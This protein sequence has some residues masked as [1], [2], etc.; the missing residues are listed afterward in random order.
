M[1]EMP[2]GAAQTFVASHAKDSAFEAGLRSF[3]EYRDLGVAKAT[4]GKYHA[5]VIRARKATTEGT[6]G[7]SHDVDFQ[8]VYVLKGWARFF[9]EGEGEV[10]VEPGS[11]VLQPPGIKHDLLECSDDL[12]MLEVT[13]PADFET[14]EAVTAP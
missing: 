1:T 14:T 3:F 12:E 13:S 6:G 5:H 11:L 8:I 2:K 4:G 9:Y 7:H 10:L